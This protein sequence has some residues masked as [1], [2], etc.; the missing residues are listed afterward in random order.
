MVAPFHFEYVISKLQ[1][2]LLPII[3]LVENIYVVYI[4]LCVSSLKCLIN[5]LLNLPM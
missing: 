2:Y 1:N 4:Y 3:L 5:T